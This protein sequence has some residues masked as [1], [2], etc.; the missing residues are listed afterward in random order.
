MVG[1]V[2]QPDQTCGVPDR[3]AN[4][5]LSLVRDI[6]SWAEQWQLPLAILRL[7]QEK[8]FD[9]VSHA[10]LMSVLEQLRF[11]PVFRAWVSLLYSRAMSRI[12]V[13]GFYSELVEHRVSIYMSLVAPTLHCL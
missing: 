4:L 1:T 3:S 8:A 7:D 9:W 10:F 11:G 12:R 5:N 13:N 2:V 6:I